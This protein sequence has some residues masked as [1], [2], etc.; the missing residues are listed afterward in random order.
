[1]PLSGDRHPFATSGR[2]LRE[3]VGFQVVRVDTSGREVAVVDFIRNA[4]D[5]P[6]SLLARGEGLIERPVAAKFAPDGSLYIVDF[7][8]LTMRDGREKVKPNTGRVFRLRAMDGA[9]GAT[10]KPAPATQLD[11]TPVTEPGVEQ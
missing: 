2:K 1:V 5:L 3:R 8:E 6:A 9:T 11:E 10:T 4:K 7:G